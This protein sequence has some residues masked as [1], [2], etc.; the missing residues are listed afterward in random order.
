M[1]ETPPAGQGA[2]PTGT[3]DVGL[4]TAQLAEAKQLNERL[5]GTQSANDRALTTLR[6]EK[7]ALTKELVDVK[8]A[9]LSVTTDL[10]ASR[11]QNSSL[12]KRVEELA[13]FEQQAADRTLE[14][15]QMRIAAVLAGSSPAISLLVKSNALPRADTAEAFETALTEIAAGLGGVIG[16]AAREQLSGV[17]PPGVQGAPPA[18]SE[19]LEE[20]AMRLMDLPGRTEEGLAMWTQALELRAKQA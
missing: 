4:L 15:S 9:S 8:A 12:S 13:P 1:T 5:T 16:D 7:Q 2:A 19:S 10:K 14:V 11:T 6:T 18:T 20:E 17:R 3:V